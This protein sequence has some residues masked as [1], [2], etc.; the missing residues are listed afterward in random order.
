MGK[1]KRLVQ[2]SG[3]VHGTSRGIKR[4]IIAAHRRGILTRMSLFVNTPWSEAAAL[5]G[6]AAPDL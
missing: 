2:T 6:R 4:G 3:T 1:T 5:L